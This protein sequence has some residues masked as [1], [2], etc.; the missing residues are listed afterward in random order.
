[1]EREKMSESQKAKLKTIAETW[2]KEA[3]EKNI[4]LI[5][6]VRVETHDGNLCAVARPNNDPLHKWIEPLTLNELERYLESIPKTEAALDG[7]EV[8][9]AGTKLWFANKDRMR[10]YGPKLG[11]NF[12]D[13]PGL[14]CTYQ[15]LNWLYIVNIR[16]MTDLHSC[17]PYAGTLVQ[18]EVVT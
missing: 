10:Q 7:E 13:N 5:G 3:R 18:I 8:R 11:G 12:T 6:G 4:V 14:A 16:K 17:E 15:Y 2:M 1:M 9:T